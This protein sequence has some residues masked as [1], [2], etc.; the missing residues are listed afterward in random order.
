M[1][2]ERIR[3]PK[4]P[5]VPWVPAMSCEQDPP[6]QTPERDLST[7]RYSLLYLAM[8]DVHCFNIT[9]KTQNTNTKKSHPQKICN[10]FKDPQK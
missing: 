5:S 4:K 2:R 6:N 7:R 3:D 10:A 8:A 9:Q 1:Q